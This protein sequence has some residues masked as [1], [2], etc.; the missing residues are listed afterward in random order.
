MK[1][2]KK[3]LSNSRWNNHCDFPINK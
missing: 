1:E 3:V 2:F